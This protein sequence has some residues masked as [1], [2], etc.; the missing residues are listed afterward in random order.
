MGSA[1]SS[2]AARKSTKVRRE[3]SLRE[4]FNDEFNSKKGLS[5]TDN[6]LDNINRYSSN[7]ND[8]N[9]DNNSTDNNENNNNNSNNKMEASVIPE[10]KLR[11]NAQVFRAKTL[12]MRPIAR[13]R[14]LKDKRII[15]KQDNS[16]LLKELYRR[17]DPVANTTTHV[18]GE[19]EVGAKFNP[20]DNLLL[21]KI[22]R[23]KHLVKTNDSLPPN[24]FVVV[25]LFPATDPE[26]V[27]TR[28]TKVKLSTSNPDFHDILAFMLRPES[29][30]HTKLRIT[31]LDRVQSWQED[32][33]GE[34]LL[35]V[36]SID[37]IESGDCSWY[38]LSARTDT[39]FCGTL[40]TSIAFEPPSSLQVTVKRANQLKPCN[41][42]DLTS[43]PYAK[44]Y[45]TTNPTTFQS[46]VFYHTLEPVW[47]ESFVFDVPSTDIPKAYIVINVLSKNNRGHTDQRLGDVHIPL[48]KLDFS[49]GGVD[50]EYV[51]KDLRNAAWSR[52]GRTDD[53]LSAEFREAMKAHVMY[54]L[55]TCIF[56]KHEPGSRV[57]ISCK[58]EKAQKSAQIVV[59]N[60]TVV[61]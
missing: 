28:K 41:E 5:F 19:L 14:G 3:K 59:Q 21:V 17:M 27:T 6:V 58:S 39:T 7:N 9:N 4:K 30:G 15:K 10:N 31:V 2:Q 44:V 32:F 20:Q 40:E 53:E 26:D 16:L 38:N 23:G 61:A 54:G 18:S 1:A 57:I 51:L 48:A 25:D 29:V 50:K 35:D 52:S 46:S 8:N 24:P 36:G 43:N 12:F 49:S 33:L 22:L 11:L 42:S 55:P 34:I 56:K 37:N 60:G 13:R 47:M 45:V